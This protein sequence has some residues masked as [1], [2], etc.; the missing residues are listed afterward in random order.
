MTKKQSFL[1]VFILALAC[2]CLFSPLAHAE[3][4]NQ[5][6]IE[7]PDDSSA[8][9]SET[10]NLGEN[11][12]A[13]SESQGTAPTETENTEATGNTENT[14]DTNSITGGRNLED[15]ST[16]ENINIDDNSSLV[17]FEEETTVEEPSIWPMVISLCALGAVLLTIIVLNLLGRRKK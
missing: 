6:A 12:D 1:G 11:G 13:N 8:S 4:I 10:V 3:E 9:G 17:D 15:G 5:G 14:S 7:V 2:G 16:V